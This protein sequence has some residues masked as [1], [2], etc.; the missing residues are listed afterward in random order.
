MKE[1]KHYRPN[2]RNKQMKMFHSTASKYTFFST[3]QRTFAKVNHILN[4]KTNLKKFKKSK[5]I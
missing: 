3:S 4:H 1:L 2:G 5:V